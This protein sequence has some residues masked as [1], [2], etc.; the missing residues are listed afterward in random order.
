MFEWH[1]QINNKLSTPLQKEEILVNKIP[2][3]DV[4]LNGNHNTKTQHTHVYK[5]MSRSPLR[6][7]EYF[8]PFRTVPALVIPHR[9][10]F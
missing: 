2:K 5:I 10:I 1:P 3:S 8:K 6:K 4:C 7:T 9:T